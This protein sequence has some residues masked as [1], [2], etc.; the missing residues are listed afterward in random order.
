LGDGAG[1]AAPRAA[2]IGQPVNPLQWERVKT[3]L[4][5]ALE[6]PA[7]LRPGYIEEISAQDPQMREELTSLLEAHDKANTEFLNTPA[8][9]LAAF[10]HLDLPDPWLGKQLGVYRLV[11]RIGAGGMGEV[12]RAVRADDEFDKQVAVKL[13]KTGQDSAFVV[14]RFRYERQI[15]AGLDHPNIAKL[16]DGGRTADGLP[17]FVMEYIAGEPIDEYCDRLKLPLGARI[18]LFLQVC[19]AVQYAHQ[20]LIVHRD[21]K[22]SNI[23]VTNDGLPKLLDFGIAK[24]LES[25]DP[26]AAEETKGLVRLL[27]PQYASPEQIRGEPITTASDVYSLGIVLYE[28]LTGGKPTQLDDR[29][30]LKPSSAVRHRGA[31]A[32]SEARNGSPAKLSRQLR[33]DLDNIV[34]MALRDEPRRRYDSVERFAE[35]LRRHL[36]FQPI[37]ARPAT[38]GY[39]TSKFVARY[40]LGVA[41]AAILTVGLLIALLVTTREANIARAERSRAERR[42]TDVRQL[43]HSLIFDIHDSIQALPGS[44]PG[45]HLIVKTG[46]RYLDDL[47]RE[48]AGDATLQQELA[49]A[50]ERLG[51]V[52]G[53]ALEANEGDYAGAADSYR[54][55]L[56]M[57]HAILQA[58]PGNRDVRRELVINCGKLSDLMWTSGKPHEAMDYSRQTIEG[59]RILVA[60]QPQNPRY[61]FMLASSLGDYGYKLWKIEN[62]GAHAIEEVRRSLAMLQQLNAAGAADPRIGRTLSL[63]YSR[64]GDILARNAS[65]YTEALSMLQNAQ[66]LM[67]AMSG[68]APDNADLAHLLAFTDHDLAGLKIKMGDLDGAAAHER[69]A[70]AAF[71][72]LAAADPK[73][74]EYHVDTAL[75]LAGLGD[76]ALHRG[77]PLQA[78]SLLESALREGAAP[79]TAAAGNDYSRSA[80]AAQWTEL[81]HAYA[82]LGSDR[83]LRPAQRAG[84]WQSA[85]TALTNAMAI[86]R[87]SSSP[88]A[89]EEA[90]TVLAAIQQC[91]QALRTL[92]SR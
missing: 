48:A 46:M 83:K 9:G 73:I 62:D 85:K 63:T 26:A 61:Q 38:L 27:T 2:A 29:Q 36:A 41:A 84:Y 45:K 68:A 11:E 23:L 10:R 21:L 50:Y 54:R 35:D 79:A 70:L 28:L 57:R 87:G 55:S 22:P 72:S 90:A 81:G 69:I 59:S 89:G 47:S 43:A 1:L 86:D 58:D 44:A 51:D 67:K 19:V 32:V 39:R 74:A 8:A 14:Q 18:R 88:G 42:F 3:A 49:A 82:A 40:R 13:L 30:P 92:P 80:Q 77:Q 33:G 52:Q 4:D 15:L 12:F 65:G 91:D 56:D 16:L 53:H 76:I 34:L 17:Y 24:I 75:A 71:S 64:A 31:D 6:L 37:I 7:A 60:S 78:A 5:V 20:R 25:G 66:Q